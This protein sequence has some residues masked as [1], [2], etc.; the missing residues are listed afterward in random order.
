MTAA[1]KANGQ[2]SKGVSGN[3]N[4]RPKRSTE[5]RYLRALR[6]YVT[7]EDWE[8]VVKT[9]LARAKA[10][11]SAARQWLSD[12]LIGKPTQRMEHTGP[13]GGPIQTKAYVTISPDDWD[14]D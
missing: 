14:D 9:A 13:D 2:W 11:D 3:P 5:E 10:G 4:G 6:R 8:K 12:Y 1:R 7:L